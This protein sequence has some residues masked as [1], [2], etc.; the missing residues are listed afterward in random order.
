MSG[1]QFPL[2]GLLRLRQIREDQARA[3]LEGAVRRSRETTARR[4]KVRDGLRESFVDVT[5]A[6]ALNAVAAAR[7]TAG[8]MLSELDELHRTDA[9]RLAEAANGYSTARAGTAAIEKLA[10]RHAERLK[11]EDERREQLELD[12]FA[13]RR[14]RREDKS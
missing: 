3:T 7:S 1:R 13:L 5:D 9:E 14:P 2:S 8:N 4:L 6:A 12:E 11:A 10:I